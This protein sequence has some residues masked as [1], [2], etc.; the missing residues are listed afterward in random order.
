MQI[1]VRPQD[2]GLGDVVQI[3]AGD[4]IQPRLIVG[5]RGG[6]AGAV[7]DYDDPVLAPWKGPNSGAVLIYPM[8]RDPVALSP[9]PERKEIVLAVAWITP[10]NIKTKMKEVVQFRAKNSALAEQPIVPAE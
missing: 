4:G 2:A 10:A 8:T 5:D 9:D 3:D 1:Q 6:I 7:A